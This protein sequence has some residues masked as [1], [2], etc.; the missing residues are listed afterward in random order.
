MRGLLI[1][2]VFCLNACQPQRVYDDTEFNEISKKNGVIVPYGTYACPTAIS[3]FK[4][5]IFYLDSAYARIVYLDSAN[6]EFSFKGKWT[7]QTFDTQKFSL[8]F[9]F[10][11]AVFDSDGIYFLDSS[12]KHFFKKTADSIIDI[13]ISDSLTLDS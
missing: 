3:I 9:P 11:H 10:Q 8:P 7:L 13:I 2:F 12:K 4:D 5:P 6:R 1:L